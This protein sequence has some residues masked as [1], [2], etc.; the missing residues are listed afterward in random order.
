MREIVKSVSVVPF[1][2]LFVLVAT[3]YVRPISTPGGFFSQIT[4]EIIIF[5]AL[6]YAIFSSILK[7]L[8]YFKRS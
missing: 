2:S 8:G 4:R 6:I 7:K 3:K 1:F 5:C